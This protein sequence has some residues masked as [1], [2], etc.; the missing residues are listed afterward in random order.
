M[1]FG[2]AIM[3]CNF[4]TNK[5]LFDYFTFTIKGVDPE[6]VITLLG[7]DGVQFM[8]SYGYY[9]YKHRYFYDGV[10]INFGCDQEGREDEVCCEMSGQGCRVYESYGNND[11]L[12]LAYY[13]LASDNAHMTRLDIAYD[14]FNGLLN[15][16]MIHNDVLNGSWVSRSTKIVETVD[17][18]I[19]G[20]DGQCVMVGKR[21]S[22]ISCRIYD[23]AKERNRQ[24]EIPHWVRCEIQLRH[25]HAD[26]F[27]YYLL[28]DDCKSIY[29][30]DI[31][32]NKRLDS[33]YFAVLNHFLRFI[34]MSGNDSNR[35]RLPLAEH[36]KKFVESYNGN[37]IS[38]YSAPGVEYNVLKLRHCVEEQYGA[39]IFT[40]IELFGTDELEDL[41]QPKKWKL[42]K[43][44]QVLLE[45]E[46]LRRMNV[47]GSDN[48]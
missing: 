14:D 7:L 20:I 33:L 31:D 15:L 6:D 13:V 39:M 36:W 23:K 30:I 3:N 5:I 8:D 12:G 4:T 32:D 46:R 38:L 42:N 41:I 10:S 2:G 29:G 47:K 17:Y 48:E 40:Y 9:G 37:G 27:L 45:S 28:C 43:K 22:N 18:K 24:D 16:D 35:W 26:N 21:D 34:D 44:Y 1:T 25:K 11:W 19:T